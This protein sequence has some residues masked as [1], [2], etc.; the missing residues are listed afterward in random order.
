MKRS[1]SGN[2]SGTR[3]AA[4]S[5]PQHIK[6]VEA[7]LH[8]QEI[9]YYEKNLASQLIEFTNYFTSEMINEAQINRRYRDKEGNT[10]LSNS[11]LK[12]AIKFKQVNTFTRPVSTQTV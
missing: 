2:K 7:M 8:Q 3:S 10:P 6:Y 1:S 12:L 5:K 11:D 4:D 9:N